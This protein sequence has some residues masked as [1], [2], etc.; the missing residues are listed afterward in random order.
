MLAT[1]APAQAAD[2]IA[3]IAPDAPSP[4]IAEAT[5]RVAAELRSAGFLVVEHHA[6]GWDAADSDVFVGTVELIQADT[7]RIQILTSAR[8]NDGSLQQDADPAD[9]LTTAE[10]IA[11]RAVESL[12]AVLLQAVRNRTLPQEDLTPA[13]QTFTGQDDPPAPTSPPPRLAPIPPPKTV[14]SPKRPTAP[15]PRQ[16]SALLSVSPTF[17]S[18]GDDAA[19]G[20]LEARALLDFGGPSVGIVVEGTVLPY[21][22]RSADG[23]V[24]V[25]HFSILFLPGWIFSS[26]RRTLQ[27]HLG[28]CAGLSQ[29][30]FDAKTSPTRSATD[31]SHSSLL[32]QG[33]LALARI[34]RNGFG[35]QI[36]GRFGSLLDVPHIRGPAMQKTLGRP[37]VSV[38]VGAVYRFPQGSPP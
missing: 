27:F 5:I 4:L 36:F 21:R 33:D 11:V 28:A 25:R 1:A 7:H 24:T 32:L 10:V 16:L 20:A 3:L 22:T 17:V 37:Y 38:G 35:A 9:P 29:M 13:V 23:T 19:S 30:Y 6:S 14:A 18:L 34:W 15:T 2:Q 8:H 26:A 12:R 31:A